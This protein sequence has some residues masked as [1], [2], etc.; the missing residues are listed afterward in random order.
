MLPAIAEM[1]NLRWA[2]WKAGKGKRSAAAVLAYQRSLEEHLRDLERQIQQAAVRVGDYCYFRIYEPKEREI[3]AAAFREQVLHHALMNVCHPIFDRSLIFDTYA[4]RK[5][6]GT[7]AALERARCFTRCYD[8]FLKLDVQKFFAN[9]H[10]DVLKGQLAR[11]FK[12]RGLLHIFFQIIDSYRATPDRGLPI[13]NLTSQYFAN[14][15]LSGWIKEDLRCRAYVRYMD[16]L[17]L[18]SNDK[19][20]LLEAHD[21]IRTRLSAGLRLQLKPCQLNRTALGLPFLGYRVFSFHQ[22]LLQKSKLRF[23]RKMKR[24]Y[25]CLVDGT[26]NEARAQAHTLPLI[27]FTEHADTV[28]YR[29]VVLC[30]LQGQAP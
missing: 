26:W 17:V 12:E 6:K 20:V 4:C 28:A 14:H 7:Y 10:H 22:R 30:H 1:E 16:D 19:S 23:G 9:I 2:F 24:I 25:R 29:K 11:L 27:A 13:G 15:Y 3:C 18:W 8:W 21:V 5:G